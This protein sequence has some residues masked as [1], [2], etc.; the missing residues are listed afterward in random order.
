MV[1]RLAPAPAYRRLGAIS[2][3]KPNRL[4]YVVMPT[5]LIAADQFMR[6]SLIVSIH[7]PTSSLVLLIAYVFSAPVHGQQ[8][9]LDVIEAARGGRHWVDTPTSPPKPPQASLDCMQIEPGLDIQLVA[10]EPLVMDPVAIA[11][12]RFGRLFV[13]EYADYPTGPQDGESPLSRL[14]YLE[15]ENQDG[16]ADRRHVFADQLNFAHSLMALDD[17]W[18]VGAQTQIL[19]LRDTDG[20]HRADEREVLFDGFTPAHPQMQIGNPRWGMDNWIYCNYGPGQVTSKVTPNTPV[21]LPRK[22]IRF[23]PATLHME[24]DSGL[25]QYGNTID[26]WGHRFYATN[27]NP[28]LCTLLPPRLL[29]R[30]P[31]VVIATGHYDVSPSGGD[32]RVFP[33]VRMKS[34][35]LSHAGTHT[36]ACG[37]TAYVGDLL[38]SKFANSVFVC[39][40]IGHLVT[41][42]IVEADGVLLKAR[43]ARESED[44]IAS[45]DTWFRPS[46]LAN[47]PDGAL[48]LADM[49]RLWVEHPKFLPKEI[50][51]RLDWRAG[52][53]RGRIYRIAPA[54]VRIRRFE[55]PTDTRGT[56]ALLDD[57][58]GWRRTL[59]Q[60]RLVRQQAK[61]A[62]SAIRTL[63]HTSPRA[64][65]RL[66][67][68]W[69]L[70][71]LEELSKADVLHGLDDVDPHVRR[72]AARLCARWLDDDSVFSKLAAKI[73]DRDTRV[74]FEIALALGDTDRA[75]ATPLLVQLAR[76]GI[77]DRWFS[78]GVLT[79]AKTRAGDILRAWTTNEPGLGRPHAETTWFLEQLGTIVGARG[80]AQELDAVF[81]LVFALD[82][83]DLWWRAAVINGIGQG[84]PRHRG[85]LGRIEL[86]DLVKNPPEGLQHVASRLTDFLRRAKQLAT[87]DS[88]SSDD[89]AALIELLAYQPFD[90]SK[91]TFE[92]LL[93]VHQPLEIQQATMRAIT[94]NGS[95]QGADLLLRRW[96]Q[97]GPAVRQPALSYVLRRTPTTK[98]L[99][100][101]MAAGLIHPAALSVDER[102]RLLKHPDQ[103]IRR[104]ATKQFGGAVS[105]N[106]QE[107]VSQYQQAVSLEASAE[108]GFVVFQ[109]ICAKCHRI[110]GVGHEAGPDLSDVGNRSRT[111]LLHDILDPNAKVEPRF[112][113]Y[114]IQTD[115]G[116]LFE[117]LI[118]SETAEAVV[119]NLG[120]GKQ[121]I[122]ARDEI[123]R[124]RASELS[125]MPEGIE[126]EVGVQEMA[127]LLEFLHVR[128][129]ASR[130]VP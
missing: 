111:A 110:N 62:A 128:Q 103:T 35:Y 109:K 23:H 68:L 83:T 94:A 105:V 112:T 31:Y 86:R 72:D 102:V 61:S 84:L 70:D 20:D 118:V 8:S 44:F 45:T 36:S 32:A 54:D 73:G 100:E 97:L 11:F 4:S 59:G 95:S 91:S 77:H 55:P 120:E 43:R 63:L 119:L 79:S 6:I 27:R 117:G 17:G 64:T 49:Y 12:D 93:Q 69:T 75:E 76:E 108:R 116:L 80:D 82:A 123:M 47:G 19:F 9:A 34:N 114:V 56:V 126:K 71:G 57:P 26:R 33:L 51:D 10:A 52:D 66:H 13:I 22:D 2:D 127:D 101:S 25:G 28:I 39:E 42:S 125:L 41:R 92:T 78:R 115:D 40:P 16:I 74:R 87:D 130:I 60:R 121:Q 18:L 99:L 50:A 122:V 7:A 67:A 89:R 98:R 37:V 24:A 58:N 46:S 106:R 96:Q 107:V 38:G 15:D 30:N 29:K 1:V 129:P 104:M 113:S 124:I 88:P 21:A 81:D 85:P 5:R 90:Q 53:D 14:V 65:T 48:Y 3:P